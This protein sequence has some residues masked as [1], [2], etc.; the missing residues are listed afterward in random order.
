MDRTAISLRELKKARTKVAL[1]EASLSLI[2]DKMFR[3][4]MLT[5]FAGKRKYPGL[6]SLSFFKKRKNC[7]FILCVFG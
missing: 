3:D 7:S 6:L 5:I 4:M 2:G 1:Y